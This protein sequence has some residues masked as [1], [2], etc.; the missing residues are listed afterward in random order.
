M[1]INSVSQVEIEINEKRIRNQSIDTLHVSSAKARALTA[2]ALE[3]NLNKIP[4][5]HMYHY[6]DVLDMD[7]TEI[8]ILETQFETKTAIVYV[9]I[10]FEDGTIWSD[11]T[12]FHF[13]RF[14]LNVRWV[15]KRRN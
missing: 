1:T 15:F 13:D 14:G 9:I 10:R 2:V 5:T 11:D 8:E 12:K 6:I 7:G 3:S 4:S